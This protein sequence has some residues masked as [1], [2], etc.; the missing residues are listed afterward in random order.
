MALP[1]SQTLPRQHGR[2]SPVDVGQTVNRTKQ[3]PTAEDDDNHSVT[4][5]VMVETTRAPPQMSHSSRTVKRFRPEPIETTTRSL[6]K[7]SPETGRSQ[8]AADYSLSSPGDAQE[9]EKAT[10]VQRSKP[11]PDENFSRSV[12][13]FKPEPVESSVRSRKGH[14]QEDKPPSGKNFLPE[15]I[16]SSTKRHRRGQAEEE[17]EEN[18]E[19]PALT[20]DGRRRRFQPELVDT[21]RGS[22]RGGGVPLRLDGVKDR[23]PPSAIPRHL[24]PPPTP[25]PPANTP[26]G[27]SE[28]V[29]QIYESRFS[30]AALAKRQEKQHCY[31]VPGLPAI[32]SDSSTEDSSDEETGKAPSTKSERSITENKT[33]S[34]FNDRFSEYLLSVAARAAERQLKDQAMAA[35]PNERIHE[36]VDH[37]AM[38]ND[39]SRRPSLN[40]KL[41]DGNMSVEFTRFRRESAADLEW[42]LENMRRHHRELDKTR[43][44][45]AAHEP[46]ESR[47][48]AAALAARL[49]SVPGQP[50]D[51]GGAWQKGVG[52]TKMRKAASPPLL[53]GDIVFPLSI[54]P[55]TTRCDVDQVPVPR[56]ADTGDSH[57]E[58]VEGLWSA[59]IRMQND[60]VSGLWMGCCQKASN[61][62]VAKQGKPGH[63]GIMT[64]APECDSA[65]S[66]GNAIDKTIETGHLP[67]TPVGSNGDGLITEV[68]KLDKKLAREKQ[69]EEEFDDAFV[70]Q[71]YNYLSL[72]YPSLARPFDHEMS[73]ISHISVEELRADDHST[74]A[75]GCIGA[76]EGNGSNA[77]GPSDRT[78]RRWTALKLYIYEWARQQPGMAQN[79]ADDWGARVRRG[80]WAF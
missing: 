55:K 79:D 58:D 36:P 9:S 74:D 62:D 77:D 3:S 56:R 67:L 75:K 61:D 80:S 23:N 40:L 2:G 54:S 35:Y 65:F 8:P 18:T 60:D 51:S 16:E 21:A 59:Q 1:M 38:A 19:K 50:N 43:E 47:F 66:N 78:C 6:K 7:R 39:D 69:I 73:K 41:S 71:I 70:T 26:V 32:P 46:G 15:P 12:R 34:D 13:K 11:Q 57:C 76:P 52:L 5:G 25:A 45:E 64:P 48:S 31:T 10:A 22:R 14:A 29:P 72:G 44:E 17:G 33:G 24:R 63:S 49:G 4:N 37:F 27:S 30:A 20:A 68:T 28:S 53:G 42:E